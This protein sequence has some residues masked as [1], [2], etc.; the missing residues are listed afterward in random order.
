MIVVQSRAEHVSV[1]LFNA[2]EGERIIGNFIG[3]RLAPGL[4]ALDPRHGG[5]RRRP[6]TRPLRDRRAPRSIRS[7]DFVGAG[8]L[9]P[10]DSGDSMEGRSGSS[11]G[12]RPTDAG[13]A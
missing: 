9:Q 1:N 5:G 6:L 4:G 10:A 7:P 8:A 3:G 2:P 13:G 12:C 11:V